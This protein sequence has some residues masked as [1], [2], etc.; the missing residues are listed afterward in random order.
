MRMRKGAMAHRA[1]SRVAIIHHLRASS[2][3][4]LGSK[5]GIDQATF[6]GDLRLRLEYLHVIG[7]LIPVLF[8]AYPHMDG[9]IDDARIGER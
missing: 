9:G 2:C 5:S 6:P 7:D 8:L 4:I 1:P 3:G